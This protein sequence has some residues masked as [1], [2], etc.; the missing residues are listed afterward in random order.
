LWSLVVAGDA[1][2]VFACAVGDGVILWR[3][4]FGDVDALISCLRAVGDG[5]E[6]CCGRKGS[7]PRVIP[8]WGVLV[9]VMVVLGVLAW[10]VGRPTAGA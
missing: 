7:A 5:D 4:V 8:A 6:L 3:I 10:G 9:V 1:W 2:D